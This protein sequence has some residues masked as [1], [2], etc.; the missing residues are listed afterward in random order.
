MID[1]PR[2]ATG[3]GHSRAVSAPTITAP[4]L[5]G[6]LLL[7]AML[8]AAPAWADQRATTCADAAEH[9][10]EL[11]DAHQL[12]EARRELVVCAQRDCPNVVRSACLEWLEQLDRRTPSLVVGVKDELGRDIAGVTVTL[13]G[14]P[15]AATV[16]STAVAVNP[17]A[18]VV[19]YAAPGF[20]PLEEPVVLREGEPLRVLSATLHRSGAAEGPPPIAAPA[21][22]RGV[23]VLPIVLGGVSV[24]ALSIFAYEGLSGAADYRRLDRD[25]GPRCSSSQIDGVRS[26]FLVADVALVVGVLTAGAA[27][28]TWLFDRPRAASATAPRP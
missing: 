19:R 7:A 24:V 25:C 22:T 9:A 16:T 5:G 21:A 28:G 4:M 6:L 15:L 17:G 1:W 13:D 12:V 11:R 20:D 3:T 23:P 18:H 10:Q 14:L 27:L 2:F 8:L 26:T